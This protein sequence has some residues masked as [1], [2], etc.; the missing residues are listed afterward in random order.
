RKG[1]DLYKDIEVKLTDVILGKEIDV[2]NLE[3]E[4]IKVKIPTG[5]KL[6]EELRV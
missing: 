5:F 1:D 4:K 2:E 6:T 3:K